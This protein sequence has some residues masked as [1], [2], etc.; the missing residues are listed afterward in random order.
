MTTIEIL[1]HEVSETKVYIEPWGE[2]YVSSK[3]NPIK[4]QITPRNENI[5]VAVNSTNRGQGLVIYINEGESFAVYQNGE[6]ID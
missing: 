5:E 2:E 3:D 4:I 6:K 1:H